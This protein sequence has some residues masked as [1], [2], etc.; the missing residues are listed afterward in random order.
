MAGRGKE[1]RWGEANGEN[2]WEFNVVESKKE[3]WRLQSLVPPPMG[4]DAYALWKKE[5]RALP[6]EA[7]IESN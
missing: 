5:D 2:R 1:L 6:W 7:K 3:L 4:S